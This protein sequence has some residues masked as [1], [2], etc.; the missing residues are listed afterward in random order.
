MNARS[1][2]TPDSSVAT[3]DRREMAVVIDPMTTVAIAP[4]ERR[5]TI[6][7]SVNVIASATLAYAGHAAIMIK[8]ATATTITHTASPATMPRVPLAIAE[9]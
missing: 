6:I 3:I 2:T 7:G 1:R 8:P 4:S 5:A 9:V